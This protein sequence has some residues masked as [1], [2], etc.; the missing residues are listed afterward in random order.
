MRAWHAHEREL[1][2]W[3]TARLSGDSSLASDLLQDVF[4][5]ALRQGSRFCEIHQA[6]AWLFEVARNTLT[7]H[8]RRHRPTEALDEAL[9]APMEDAP[10]AVD[11][12][13]SCLPRVLNELSEADRDAIS[14]CDLGGMSQEAYFLHPPAS[15]GRPLRL[16]GEPL[17][18]RA[19]AWDTPRTSKRGLALRKSAGV[20]PP[21]ASGQGCGLMFVQRPSPPWA[22][23]PLPTCHRWR[24]TRA[25]S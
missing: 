15:F 25:R 22:E 14:H 20:M 19:C 8:W 18:R 7:D 6:R 5:K 9:P 11:T 21:S 13:A 2:A 10:P 23:I 24:S 4:I 1:Q 12:L 3:L 16:L 17:R